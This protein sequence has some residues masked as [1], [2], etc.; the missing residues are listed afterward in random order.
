M[1]GDRR[2]TH[3]H[4]K[5]CKTNQCNVLVEWK[6]INSWNVT[7]VVEGQY[8]TL[9]RIFLLDI[10]RLAVTMMIYPPRSRRGL[11]KQE[12]TDNDDTC[13][14]QTFHAHISFQVSV[15]ES[16]LTRQDSSAGSGETVVYLTPKEILA[17]VL[18]FE[19]EPFSGFDA[20]YL[21]WLADEYYGVK[22]VVKRGWKD[23]LSAVF[24]YG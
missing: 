12:W 2:S 16:M 19:L 20:W 24:G 8:T 6:I 17:F 1:S 10:S 11:A 9:H 22:V 5:K 14:L 3:L 4:S 7:I 21:K 13:D 18:A 23:L 15:L